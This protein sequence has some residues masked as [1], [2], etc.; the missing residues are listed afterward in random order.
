MPKYLWRNKMKGWENQRNGR[1]LGVLFEETEH[2]DLSFK[3]AGIDQVPL[4][5]GG[6]S[7]IS[8]ISIASRVRLII[9]RKIFHENDSIILWWRS[10]ENDNAL[11]FYPIILSVVGLAFYDQYLANSVLYFYKSEINI[12]RINFFYFIARKNI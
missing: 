8:T 2:F 5:R 4:H 1:K 7:I 9:F 3:R 6:I 10:P 12:K 11:S